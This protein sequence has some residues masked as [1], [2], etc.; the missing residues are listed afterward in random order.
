MKKR[1]VLMAVAAILVSGYA[2][3]Q[4]ASDLTGTVKNLREQLVQR[5]TIAAGLNLSEVKV[6]GKKIDLVFSNNISDFPW[7]AEDVAWFREE[8]SKQWP[9]GWKSYSLGDIYCESV[10]LDEM[11]TNSIGNDGNA[12]KYQYK[13]NDPFKGVTPLVER[14]SEPKFAKGLD[15][16]H[17]S[18][19]QSHGRYYEEDTHRW[20]WQRAPLLGTVEDMYTQ[21][22]VIPFLIPM[23]ENAGAYVLTPRERDTNRSETICDNDPS[24]DRKNHIFYARTAGKYSESGKWEDAG[25]GFADAKRI[26]TGTE[27]PFTMG[28]ARQALCNKKGSTARIT[29]TADLKKDGNYAVYVS[30]KT[31]PGSTDC[32][33][34][35]VHHAGGVS[36]FSVNQQMG[37]STWIYLGSF[38]FRKDGDAYVTLDNGVPAGKK[39]VKNSVV[40]ADAVRF[41]GGMGKIARGDSDAPVESY[42]TSGLP[43]YAEGAM[44]WMQWAGVPSE[45]YNKFEDDYTN[46]YASRGAWTSWMLNEK[47]VPFD[48]SFAFH[49]DAGTT[50]DDQTVGTLSIYT[51]LADESR[52]T[53]KGIDRMAGRLLADYVQEQICNDVRE[54]FNPEWNKRLLWDRSYSESRTTSVPGMLIEFLSHQNLAD[55]K[56]GMDPVFRFEVSRAIYKGMLKTL[57]DLYGV[58]YVVQPLPA[59]NFSV[60]TDGQNALL[61]WEP[62]ADTKEPTATAKSYIVQTRIDEGAFDSGISVEGTSASIRILPQH[63]YSFRVIAVNEGGKSFPSEILSVAKPV[64]SKGKILVVNNFDR[65][66]APTWFDTPTVAGFNFKEDCGV[67]YGYEINRIGDQY[68]FNRSEPWTDDDNPGFGATHSDYAGKLVAGNTFDFVAKHAKALLNLGYTVV[69]SSNDAFQ[70]GKADSD[71]WTLDLLCGKQVTTKIGNGTRPNRYQ[72]F[73][74][75]LQDKVRQLTANGVNVVISGSN[76]AT[77]AW[78]SVYPIEV[79]KAYQEGAQAF[80][81]DILGYKYLTSHG[82]YTGMLHFLNENVYGDDRFTFKQKINETV[83]CVENPDGIVPADENGQTVLSYV[84]N[85]IPASVYSKGNGYKVS[86]YGFPIEVLS[87][88]ESIEKLFG[89]AFEFFNKD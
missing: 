8:L 19:W 11:I 42:K 48:L 83:Y 44:Y 56:H 27:N 38:D 89:N 84:G 57:S 17:I 14:L 88:E 69:S 70:K 53:A 18:I 71:I 40:T 15:G 10:R 30:Y 2:W 43:S 60:S 47:K 36:E 28:T 22:Y 64:E 54:D 5:T 86:A 1:I 34:Y 73:P 77:D 23:L 65:V 29:W 16:R 79:D 25:E 63:V 4:T 67:A 9:V 59:G 51:L 80:C 20:E 49:T 61:S 35:T 13:V 3:C 37:G 87:K 45:V 58:H 12:Q 24:F 55:M 52:E 7:R 50:L 33:H 76:I 68:N 6:N 85:D 81:K 66:S 74:E 32:A 78:S 62:T 75:A 41:G 82:C 26:Y 39:Y 31:V 21:S 72:I 46:D